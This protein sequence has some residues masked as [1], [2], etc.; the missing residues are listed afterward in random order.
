M[1]ARHIRFW[2]IA[3]A[4]FLAAVWLLS[5]VLLPF[6]AGMAIAYFLDPAADRAES[7]GLPR[8]AAT[9]LALLVFFLAA[10]SA[11]LLLTPLLLDQAQRLIAAVPGYVTA[12]QTKV[13]PRVEDLIEALPPE[14]M[15]RVR[16]AIGNSFGT[17]MSLVGRLLGGIL[18]GGL[19]VFDIISLLIITPVV[20][21]YLLRDWDKLIA[22]LDD[23]IPRESLATV[24][25]Q[26]R[27][28]D[29]TLAGFVRGQAIVCGLLGL[30]YAVGLTAVGLDFGLVVGLFAGIVS[31]IPFVGSIVGLLL[32]LGLAFAQG[33]GWLL[34]GLVVAV[35]AVG[36]F[37]EGN[38]LQPRLVGSRVGL[39]AVWV[40]FALLA[41]GSLFGFLG[42][43]LAVPVAAVIGVLVRF[44]LGLYRD[45]RYYRGEITIPTEP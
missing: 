38:I 23:M 2:L 44:G 13:I 7:R 45:S 6:V 41:G 26:A 25:A 15:E 31:F 11:L 9:T 16:A 21:F 43:L 39:H 19:A 33:E 18:A 10:V 28:V 14:H 3:F 36:Q 30:I 4:V 22:Q 1:D 24:R 5:D 12:I 29:D 20:A 42:V 37:I 32:G 27:I 8:W 17:A 34:P 40:M 35:F